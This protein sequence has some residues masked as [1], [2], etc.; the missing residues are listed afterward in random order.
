MK[1]NK[2]TIE[3]SIKRTILVSSTIITFI[4]ATIIG[5]V[6]LKAEYN[7]FKTHIKSFEDTLIETE[8]FSIKTFVEN[9]K[10]DI[11]FEKVSIL[12][13]KKQRIKNQS[14]I[15]YNLA[16]TISD[17]VNN[18]AKNEQ[19]NIIKSSIKN[20]ASIQNDI[21]YFILDL[22]GKM[23]LNTKNPNAQGIN[24]VDFED[25]NGIKFIEEMIKANKD[26]QNYME[27]YWYKPSKT[28]TYSRHLKKLGLIIGSD[29]FLESS[30]N[31]L[32]D[33]LLKRVSLK[34]YKKEEFLFIYKINSLNNI[35]TKSDLLYERNILTDETELKVM[36][37]MMIESNYKGGRHQFYDD[38]QKLLYGM[39]LGDFRY[40]IAIG[41]E[42][43]HINEIVENEKKISLRNMYEKII[44]VFVLIF[45]MAFIFFIFSFM[46]KKKIEHLF[47]VYR[48]RVKQNE[49]KYALLFNHSNDGFIISEVLEDSTSIL[50]LNNMSLKITGY[51]LD[52]ILY[53][54]IFTLFNSL[55]LN[56][57][58]NTEFLFKTVTLINKNK[59]IRTIELN[60]VFYTYEGQ[61]LLFASLRDI[62]ER[63][64][65]K[66]EK[67]KQNEII[68]QKSKMAAMG[69]M[70]GNIAHQWRQPLSQ[71]SGLFFD[72]E[73]A[74]DYGELDKKY[75]ARN[76]DEANNILEYMSKTIDDFRNFFNPNSKKENFLVKDAVDHA[77]KII[78]STLVFHEIELKINIYDDIK[79]DGYK[80]EYSQAIL[81][82]ISNAKDILIEKK[83]KNPKINIS[84]DEENMSLSIE[85]NAGGIDDSIID[86][87]F[88][89]YFTTKFEYGTGIG[90]Y[91][92]KLIIENK[93]DGRISVENSTLGARF[94]IK[95]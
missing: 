34:N 47:N 87:I 16:S 22:N 49:E 38:R 81:N 53:T 30:K 83:I 70:I 45:I 32:K 42:L 52:E 9:L 17:K 64:L 24:V 21:N 93:M 71:I 35:D 8:M 73:S 18:L 92:T 85:D 89:P 68:I 12:N 63:T 66:E 1:K 84:F 62:T 11:E 48:K 88:D 90:L 54:D 28:I 14:I 57:I 94:I 19:I 4:V 78:N 76:I 3:D 74:Y 46:F 15:A 91:M 67:K 50:S 65:L 80:N 7:N 36:K 58:L 40:F 23:I 39:F 75:L 26:T 33:K 27:Y 37:E 41:S 69:E 5:L 10:K 43:S 13:D 61:K 86:K 56:D 51:E 79:I 82:I 55:S 59:E 25:I 31:E 20:L 72:I 6:L 29:S 2:R 95:V 60:V 44:T 77:L